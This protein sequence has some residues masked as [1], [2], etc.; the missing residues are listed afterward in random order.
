MSAPPTIAFTR[1]LVRTA[2]TACTLALLPGA[3]FAAELLAPARDWSLPV[4][5]NEG[6][7][8]MIARG[9][10]ARMVSQHQFDVVDLN[11]TIFT[12]DAANHIETIILSPAA[13]FVS[14]SRM[15]QG[16]KYVR[17]IRFSPDNPDVPEVEATGIRWIYR[18]ADKKISLDGN[19]R[20][21]FRAEL[22][23]LLR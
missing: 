1:T 21:T 19:V 20:V 6:F 23:D 15:A 3:T 13:T 18:H 14:N 2:L 10:E 4:F 7:R 12:G 17:F 16:E 5:T 9:S 22:T 11:L 8:S